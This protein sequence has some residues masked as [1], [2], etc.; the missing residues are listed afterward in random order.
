MALSK[1]WKN[2]YF[3][4]VI[5]IVLIVGIILGLFLG[6]EFGLNTAYPAL[7][8]IS[9]SMYIAEGGPNYT[10]GASSNY[11]TLN[12]FWISLTHPFSRTLS[13]GD[14]IIIEGVNPKDLN[15]KYPNSDIIVFHSPVNGEL[16][17][18]RITKSETVNSVIY[19]QTKGD[20]NG[21]SWPQTPQNG[22]DPWDFNYPPGV[23]Q[24]LVAGKVIARIPFFGWFTIFTKENSWGLPIIVAVIMILVVV[25]FVLPEVRKK[26]REKLGLA[27]DSGGLLNQGTEGTKMPWTD[28]VSL[29]LVIV[30]FLLFLF[31]ANIYSVFVGYLGLCMLIGA[32][33]AY[34]LLYTYNKLVFHHPSAKSIGK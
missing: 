2:D 17:V 6:L 10:P 29:G 31:G 7:T 25:E 4:T 20:G 24:N 16:I 5:A 13:V 28:W 11:D 8:V 34:V 30:G 12:D 26:R 15:A 1:V 14:I 23:P 3:K 9:P 27:R 22:L 33:V 19:F 32:F 18:H 21:N